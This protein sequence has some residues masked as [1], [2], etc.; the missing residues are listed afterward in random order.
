MLN[1]D[2]M[3]QLLLSHM[4]KEPQAKEEKYFKAFPV[5]SSSISFLAIPCQNIMKYWEA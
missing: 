5:S 4:V 1:W 2:A 3:T